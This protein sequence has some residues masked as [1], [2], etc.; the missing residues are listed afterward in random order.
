MKMPQ[1]IYDDIR[2]LKTFSERSNGDLKWFIKPTPGDEIL[3]INEVTDKDKNK[4][5]T[6]H[7][8]IS[9]TAYICFLNNLVGKLIKEVESKYE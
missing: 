1:S 8:D 5:F 2:L 6:V 7:G 9:T 4:L 3:D